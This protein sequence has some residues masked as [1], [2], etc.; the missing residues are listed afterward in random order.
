MYWYQIICFFLGCS[1]V[2]ASGKSL[3]L[4]NTTY[5]FNKYHFKYLFHVIWLNDKEYPSDISGWLS[6]GAEWR[7]W[8]WYQLSYMY[9]VC[10]SVYICLFVIYITWFLVRVAHSLI[11]CVVFCR[12]LFDFLLFCFGRWIDC[13]LNCGFWLPL[14]HVQTF[15]V[16][17]LYYCLHCSSNLLA[18]FWNTLTV[19]E[20]CY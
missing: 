18:T 1:L 15:L 5:G 14:W 16:L 2:F 7:S 6:G 3:L 12:P 4:F 9:I 11:F 17:L 8:Y 13:P 20:I 19:I 10:T